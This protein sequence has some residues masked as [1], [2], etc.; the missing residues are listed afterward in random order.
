TSLPVGRRRLA[1]ED[2]RQPVEVDVRELPLPLLLQPRDQLRAQDVQLP[3]QKAATVRDVVLL[4][5][6]LVDQLLELGVRDAGE[7]RKRFHRILS[8]AGP[9]PLKQAPRQGSTSA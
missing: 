4:G 1:G 7:V 3:V 2:L 9:T 6:E 5:L 8:F